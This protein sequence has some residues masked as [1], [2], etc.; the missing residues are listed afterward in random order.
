MAKL[1][2]RIP[3]SVLRNDVKYD[4]FVIS[5]DEDLGV[6]F[7]C[8][9]QFPEVRT[10]EVLAKL[11]DVV[12]SSGGSNR[13]PQ[14][15]GHAACSSSMPVGASSVVPEIAPEAVLA[16]SP[17]FAFNLNC[18]GNPGVGETRPLG[19]VAIATPD[20]PA[21]VPVF[22][23]VGVQDGQF[24]DKEEVA[25]SMKTYSIRCG[26]EYKVL[27][28]DHRKYYGKCKEF[29]S[30]CP[31]LIRV[32]LRQRRGIWEVKRYNGPHTCL[33]TSIS[34]DH[35]KLN[36]HV[37][38][39]FI[40]PMIRAD[41]T[42]SI[43]ITMPGTIAVLKTSPMR[44]GGQVDDSAGYFH[45]LF[46]TFPLCIEAFYHC[47]PLVSVDGTHLYGKYGGTLLVAI[48]Q[49]GNS[50]I[51]PIAFALVEGENAELW[52]FSI[53]HVVA[54]FTLNFKGKDAQRL[55]I[56]AAYAKTEAEFHY[57]FDILH[58]KDLTMC[59]WANRI[60]YAHWT[61]H[62]DE[63]RRFG[64]MTT[65]ISECVNS[66]LKGVRNLPICALVKATYGRL[67]ELFVQKRRE[68]KA[69]LGTEQ[70]F[71]QHLI[72]EIKANLKTSWCFTMTVY[73]RD[74]SE[75]TVA[76]TTPTGS[77]SLGT[78]RVSLTDQTCDCDYFQALH[79]PCRHALA[80]C[81][82]ARLTWSTYVH[83]VY[84]LSS[85]FDVYRMV[86]TPP[87]PEGFWPPYDG[88]TVIPNPAKRH[89]SE[90]RPRTTKI[91][92]TMDEAD[93]NRAKR[94]KLCRHPGHTRRRCPQRGVT[95]SSASASN[96][97]RV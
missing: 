72:K 70:Q 3:I 79:Y 66:I 34:S 64:H 81:A 17:S 51:I 32:S 14:S 65:N 89:A 47:K 2:Y 33:A 21:K 41:A 49:H 68:A 36:Y 61:H 85:V 58:A 4:S 92:T 52:A 10:P 84:R 29:D 93:P 55:L 63:G 35:R 75:F 27:E 94:C 88:P 57:W 28:S 20:S 82:Y 56:N 40:L 24:Q 54:N 59:D 71:S 13:N 7:H 53:R 97:C 76:E 43:K 9:R 15:T 77:F 25:L 60:D 44:V 62:W 22:G 67:A 26:V 6:L 86:F 23:E 11:V 74:N 39:A 5:S 42:V 18:S 37:I 95:I 31:W 30:G 1:F 8:R 78:Y 83:E 48:A 38:S 90:G 69:Q 80:C 91:R 96:V 46:W 50:N 12:S 87:I 45:R 16:A 19:K 73:D